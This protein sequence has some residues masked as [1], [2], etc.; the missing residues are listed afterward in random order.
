MQSVAGKIYLACIYKLSGHAQQ[1]ED[2]HS[3]WVV[4][5]QWQWQYWLGWADFY[6]RQAGNCHLGSN[7]I[8]GCMPSAP[9]ISHLSWSCCRQHAAGSQVISGVP[10]IDLEPTLD[11]QVVMVR[12][13]SC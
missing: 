4:L 1:P 8:A 6:R 2:G 3:A 7:G 9:F 10:H 11:E 5:L 12:A 13:P